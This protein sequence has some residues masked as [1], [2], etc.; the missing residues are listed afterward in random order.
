MTISATDDST[1]VADVGAA[2]VADGSAA[3][4]ARAGTACAGTPA[5]QAASSS[6]ATARAK[7]RTRF[8]APRS[9]RHGAPECAA[10]RSRAVILAARDGMSWSV[11]YIASLA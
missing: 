1:I 11:V 6:D 7:P 5:V 2:A 3:A 10:P 9:V 4:T 8:D